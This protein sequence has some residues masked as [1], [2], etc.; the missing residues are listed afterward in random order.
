MSL[1]AICTRTLTS[2]GYRNTQTRQSNNKHKDNK[3]TLFDTRKF[4]SQVQ[5]N[6]PKDN[7]GG[8]SHIHIKEYQAFQDKTKLTQQIN[9][10]FPNSIISGVLTS[11]MSSLVEF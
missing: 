1:F 8:V 7:A 5:S 10:Y 6:F 3:R 11:S 9:R 4:I 2:Y